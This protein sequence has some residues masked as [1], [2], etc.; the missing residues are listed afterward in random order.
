MASRELRRGIVATHFTSHLLEHPDGEYSTRCAGSDRTRL[1]D[2]VNISIRLFLLLLLAMSISSQSFAR[3]ES[4]PLTDFTT[5]PIA[6]HRYLDYLPDPEHRLTF[7]EVSAPD[8]AP[9]F[10]TNTMPQFIRA[11]HPLTYWF[12]I[13]VHSQ[14]DAQ[15]WF[16]YLASSRYSQLEF[17]APDANGVYQRTVTGSAFAFDTRPVQHQHFA[18]PFKVSKG[19][20]VQLYLRAQIQAEGLLW[21]PAKIT[22]PEQLQ[23]EIGAHDGLFLSFYAIM[24][25]MLLYNFCLYL[26][27]KLKALLFYCITVAA[28]IG[29]LWSLDGVNFRYI[30]PDQP[31]WE[32][33]SLAVI[34]LV[35]L[36]THLVFV[37]EIL[38]IHKKLTFLVW[39]FRILIAC[40]LAGFA[41]LAAMPR[42]EVALPLIQI[43]GLTTMLLILVAV[44]AGI[45]RRVPSANYF[46]LSEIFFCAGTVTRLTITLGLIPINEWTYYSFH[47]GYL[48]EVVLLSLALADRFRLIQK[49]KEELQKVALHEAESSIMLKDQFLTTISHEMRT[50]IAGVDAALHLLRDQNLPAKYERFVDAAMHSTSEM[51]VLV[52]KILDFAEVQSGAMILSQTTINLHS[53]LEAQAN[54][55][56]NLCNIKKLNFELD[57]AADVPDHITGDATKLQAILNILLDNA[58]KYTPRGGISLSVKKVEAASEHQLPQLQFVVR[59]TGI[60]IPE[61]HQH[62]I[63]EYFQQADSSFSRQHGG[64]GIGLSMCKQL[65]RLFNGSISFYSVPGQ[66]SEFQVRLPVNTAES[67]APMPSTD[68]GASTSNT[69][70]PI[71]ARA[72]IVEDNPVNML[73]LSALLEKFGLK[74]SGASSGLEALQYLEQNPVDI[75]FMDCQMPDMDGFE[76]TRRL[77]AGNG[78]NHNIPVIAVTA[79]AMSR[80]I[81][82][83]LDAGMDDH[84]KK[85]IDRQ[86]LYTKIRR[87]LALSFSGKASSV[88]S[89]NDSLA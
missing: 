62:R 30:W 64:L 65:T 45:V 14:S 13:T 72:L 21:M 50:P 60:G 33:L 63:F 52:D 20:Q 55:Y 54:R 37:R 12:R 61:E 6:L 43:N 82:R 86:V 44:I 80:D 41:A 35:A 9:R 74:V 78:P 42:P 47:I 38:D 36:T 48:F 40:N 85:P 25:C 23:I 17:F 7:A 22:T 79:N 5:A 88:R 24:A 66:G 29:V 26:R 16:L 28:D 39:P 89:T 18:F 73:V 77:R 71:D 2:S 15:K 8:M 19:Q 46:L 10:Q 68:T 59:D 4:V 76:T 32:Q 87:L 75:V 69:F 1:S 57:I 31:A 67:D 83:C 84:V 3:A 58:V 49:E 81:E 34:Y 27:L 51:I 53:L 56:R 11:G 70:A